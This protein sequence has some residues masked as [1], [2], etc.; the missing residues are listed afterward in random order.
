MVDAMNT[1]KEEKIKIFALVVGK[2][3]K[4]EKN[5]TKNCIVGMNLADI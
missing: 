5:V 3:R 4:N 2:V 1:A